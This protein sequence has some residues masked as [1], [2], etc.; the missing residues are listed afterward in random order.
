MVERTR[1]LVKFAYL[2]TLGVVSN[3]PQLA[4][5][6]RDRGFPPG[7]K[8]GPKSRVW[9]DT[10]IEAWLNERPLATVP[11]KQP[12]HSRE[13]TGRGRGRPRKAILQ[14]AAQ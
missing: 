1:K 13:K 8:L 14:E 4:N 5:L 6:I 3:R 12:P 10:E 2:K 11:P 7:R 9:W